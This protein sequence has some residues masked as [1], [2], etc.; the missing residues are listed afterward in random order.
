M[1]EFFLANPK[2][3]KLICNKIRKSFLTQQYLIAMIEKIREC[4]DKSDTSAAI[5]TTFPKS[6]D[7]LPHNLL[8]P[9]LNTHGIEEKIP[10]IY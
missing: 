10:K 3:V 8:I 7:C 2:H 6:F 1:E 4:L 5:L 9:K